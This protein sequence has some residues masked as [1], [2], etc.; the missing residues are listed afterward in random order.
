M[1]IRNDPL[2]KPVGCS[3]GEADPALP[4]LP[5]PLHRP[6]K[7]LKPNFTQMVRL[8]ITYFQPVKL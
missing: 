3:P 8:H 1:E 4:S 2:V 5:E 7:S 6:G